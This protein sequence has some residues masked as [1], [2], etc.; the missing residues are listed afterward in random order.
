MLRV[1]L[2]AALCC[3]FTAVN[4]QQKVQADSLL[5]PTSIADDEPDALYADFVGGGCGGSLSVGLERISYHTAGGFSGRMFVDIQLGSF[6]S[7]LLLGARLG[8]N[9][10]YALLPSLSIHGVAALGGG[11]YSGVE[12]DEDDEPFAEE[13]ALF[14]FNALTLT[15]GSAVHF[16]YFYPL[17]LYLKA[18]VIGITGGGFYPGVGGGVRYA[19]KSKK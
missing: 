4:A 2:L 18:E 19:F 15:C 12:S 13:D 11:L 16:S 14:S 6:G 8:Y 10:G 17:T 7:E 5:T 9:M 1:T 3:A